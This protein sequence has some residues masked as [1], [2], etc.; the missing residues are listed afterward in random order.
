[1]RF[2]GIDS[3]KRQAWVRT[4]PMKHRTIWVA[5]GVKPGQPQHTVEEA[6]CLAK[7]A[8]GRRRLVEIGVAEGASAFILRRVMDPDGDLWLIDPFHLTRNPLFN[9]ELVAA[10]RTVGRCRRGRIHFLCE[11]SW[12]VS[13]KWYLPIDYLF[14]DGDHRYERVLADWQG[15]AP[16]VEPGG[17]VL[18]HDSVPARG[19]PAGPS[20]AVDQL[21]RSLAEPGWRIVEETGTIVVVRREEMRLTR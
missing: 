6:S 2:G 19:H 12:N 21:F 20:R 4:I 5:L 14:I 9:T 13:K 10:R 18:F 3:S 17:V 11:W 16:W 1:M 15:F 7:W 8:G